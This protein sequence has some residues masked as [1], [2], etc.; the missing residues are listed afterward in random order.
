MRPLVGIG[1]FGAYTTFSTMAM[2]GVRLLDQGRPARSAGY[3]LATL[4]VGQAAG[5]WPYAAWNLLL[6]GPLS[7]AGA[8]FLAR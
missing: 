8:F 5:A 4:L 7:F 3:W 6:S 2:E 1:F